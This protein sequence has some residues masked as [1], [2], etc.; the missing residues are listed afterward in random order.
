MFEFRHPDLSQAIL[1]RLSYDLAFMMGVEWDDYGIVGELL[2]TNTFANEFIAYVD[3]SKIIR[4]GKGGNGQTIS[5]RM[6]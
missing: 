2:G 5:E 1:F 4:N 3:L 6:S